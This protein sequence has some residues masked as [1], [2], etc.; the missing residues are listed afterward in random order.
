[1]LELGIE[2]DTLDAFQN[3]LR[4]LADVYRDSKPFQ[5]VISNP[6]VSVDERH[7]I[8]RSIAE[9]AGWSAMFRNFAML[10]L[11]NDRFG[12]VVDI[13]EELDRLVDEHHGIVRASVT[14]AQELKDSQVAV[15]KGAIAK[16]TGK[17]VELT[18]EVDPAIIG[19]AVTRVGTTVYDGSVRTQLETMRETVLHEI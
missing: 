1:L 7:A 14:T 12:H 18:S 6:G 9:R 11:D 3:D 16:M 10:L 19:G 4:E 5:T 13:A 8:V 17:N 15:I 2:R